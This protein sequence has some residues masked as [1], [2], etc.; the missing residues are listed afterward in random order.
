MI[1]SIINKIAN[2]FQW[3]FEDQADALRLARIILI[4]SPIGILGAITSIAKGLWLYAILSLVGFPTLAVVGFAATQSVAGAIGGLYHS[5]SREMNHAAIIKGMYSLAAGYSK[6]GQFSMARD[7]YFELINTYPD[8]LDA[9]YLLANL[10]EQHYGLPEEALAEF[11]KLS[12]MIRE[13]GIDYKYKHA[14][15]NRIKELR[16]TLEEER[17]G[18]GTSR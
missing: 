2:A 5:G 9:R 11:I 6:T 8:E 1:A 17:K 14:L 18:P 12:R 15:E 3:L 4:A 7:K 16:L 10:L 13:K